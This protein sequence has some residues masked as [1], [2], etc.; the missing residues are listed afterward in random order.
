MNWWLS[1]TVR[2]TSTK[3]TGTRGQS[4]GCVCE[5]HRQNPG[6]RRGPEI[7]LTSGHQEF[8]LACRTLPAS[9]FN[10]NYLVASSL[11]KLRTPQLT[12]MHET[13]SKAA[14]SFHLSTPYSG[15]RPPRIIEDGR[16]SF[17]W[18]FC[19]DVG[20][21][22][23]RWDR[24]TKKYE[25]RHRCNT[26]FPSIFWPAVAYLDVLLENDSVLDG[27]GPAGTRRLKL[28]CHTGALAVLVTTSDHSD[29][30]RVDT[31]LGP[32]MQFF[33]TP[34][35]CSLVTTYRR[36]PLGVAKTHCVRSGWVSKNLS[37]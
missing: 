16:Q 21:E 7:T 27:P 5:L 33:F 6:R 29:D 12:A 32:W 14:E 2:Y 1:P 31:Y 4:W 13:V 10:G 37:F 30:R 22:W 28:F 24:K 34:T 3:D 26:F 17:G 8:V 25:Q 18:R 20:S 36:D 11:R 15:E 35:P 23:W 19:P 9:H